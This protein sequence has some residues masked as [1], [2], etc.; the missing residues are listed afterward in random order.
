MKIETIILLVTGFFFANTYYEGKLIEKGKFFIKSY[1]KYYE[2]TFYCFLGLCFYL[3]V[4]KN[5]H[6][7]KNMLMQASNLV[8]F[9]PV[10][11]D[12][13]SIL[14]P[15]FNLT[16]GAQALSSF[17]VTPQEKRMLQ[18]GGS[19]KRSVSETKKK[20]VASEQNWHCGNC[21][22]QLQAHFEVDHKIRLDQG[23]SNNVDNLVALCRNCHGEKTSIEN[24]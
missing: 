16:T 8:K 19:G 17:G 3:L 10:D 14:N 2:I 6:Q 21:K 23:G 13:M 5:P 4:R 22:A 11:K 12:A 7:G 18:S 24:L 20:W 15:I 1:K 9:A